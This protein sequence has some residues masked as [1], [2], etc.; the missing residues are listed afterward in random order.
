M[1]KSSESFHARGVADAK[2][3]EAG[4]HSVSEIIDREQGGIPS[5]GIA[6][7]K[8]KSI[9][10]HLLGQMLLVAHPNPHSPFPP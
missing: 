10:L 6:E 8:P 7:E 2:N 9:S 4:S 3:V 1:I 5:E